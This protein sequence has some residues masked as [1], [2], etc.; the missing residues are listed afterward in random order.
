MIPNGSTTDKRSASDY[1]QSRIDDGADCLAAAIDLAS[2]GLSILALCPPDHMGVGKAHAKHCESPGKCPWGTWK[3][4]QDR[5][6]TADE[7]RKKWNDNPTLNIGVALGPVSNLVR[8]DVDSAAAHIELKNISGGNLPMTWEFTSGRADGTGY[9][10]LWSIPEGVVF[11]TTTLK[12]LQDG[13]LRFQAKGSQTVLP[14]SRHKS[15]NRYMWVRGRSPW[16]L[17]FPAPAP[18]WAIER[19]QSKPQEYKPRNDSDNPDAARVADALRYVSD[20]DNYQSWLRVGMALHDWDQDNGYNLWLDWSRT[21][22]KFDEE[23]CSLKWDSFK[24]SSNGHRVTILSVF[25]DAW[26]KGWKPD[27]QA[28]FGDGP[29]PEINWDRFGGKARGS[30]TSG[31]TDNTQA[32]DKSESKTDDK[33]KDYRFKFNPITSAQLATGDFRLNWLIDYTLAAEQAGV[34]GAFAKSMKTTIAIDLA[35]SLGTATPFLGK[36]NV[37]N[38]VRVAMLSGESGKWVIQETARRIAKSK[39]VNLADA[40][41]LWGFELPQL[42]DLMDLSELAD[43]LKAAGVQVVII[44]PLYLCLLTGSTSGDMSKNVYEMGPHLLAIARRCLEIGV[45]PLFIHHSNRTIKVGEPMELQHLSGAG[46]AEFVRQWVLLNRESAY[47]G[48]GVH[49]IWMTIGGSAGQGGLHL[50]RIEEGTAQSEGG[51]HW[52]VQVLSA[53]DAVQEKKETKK[54]KTDSEK[55]ANFKANV[56]RCYELICQ[57]CEA[58]PHLVIKRKIRSEE[59]TWSDTTVDLL[60][61]KLLTDGRIETKTIKPTKGKGGYKKPTDGYRPKPKPAET[62]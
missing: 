12:G 47:E 36:F 50:V 6:A 41:V 40:E 54:Q 46:V 7:L 2:R 21:S 56:E 16:E 8:L 28:T 43:G 35:L 33:K 57:L 14:P 11:Q 52:D 49:K 3:E 59:P 19:Y 60:L 9:G 37:R 26:A 58:K 24:P 27:P 10:Y 38:K 17:H 53:S 25:K 20:N 61:E 30:T 5:R 29:E 39:G 15:D 32:G 44:D 55:A 42:S 22:D 45:T 23:V 4:F 31:T 62:F 18:D 13:E 51:R 1:H 48:D 34:I